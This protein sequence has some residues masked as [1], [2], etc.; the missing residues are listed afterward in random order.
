[1][2]ND[3]LSAA[4]AYDRF[5]QHKY[6][7]DCYNRMKGRIRLRLA[8]TYE[9]FFHLAGLHKIKDI[10]IKQ[11]SRKKTFFG[12]LSESGITNELIKTSTS[13]SLIEDRLSL[14]TRLYKILCSQKHCSIYEWNKD[15]ARSKI[16][17]DFLLVHRDDPCLQNNLVDCYFIKQ[18]KD[19]LNYVFI[20][21]FSC[22]FKDLTTNQI[23]LRM[24]TIS[25]IKLEQIY[26]ASA[27]LTHEMT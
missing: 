24:V 7:L 18:P 17:A 22:S 14:I 25:R 21:C 9:D 6:E 15:I 3:L 2:A 10:M 16:D 5:C 13:F 1:M 23:K 20:S 4:T 19:S 11:E 27:Q 8:P 26:P 12:I